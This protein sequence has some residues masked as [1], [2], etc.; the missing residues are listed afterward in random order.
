MLAPN[1]ERHLLLHPNMR[2]R[3]RGHF[4]RP[5]VPRVCS[6]PATPHPEHRI[7]QVSS[8]GPVHP[9]FGGALH[10]PCQEVSPQARPLALG[11]AH[12]RERLSPQ[13]RQGLLPDQPAQDGPHA[14]PPGGGD[15]TE[16]PQGLHRGG[17]VAR[18][19][20]HLRSC[21]LPS[22]RADVPLRRLPARL[23]H[24]LLPWHPPRQLMTRGSKMRA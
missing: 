18:R 8:I 17:G 6:G 10:P 14:V 23:R 24:Q 5:L 15:P 22:L 12:R 7:L 20:H 13:L 2:E 3:T 9:S 4:L 19:G 16:R 21:H 1:T 11:R